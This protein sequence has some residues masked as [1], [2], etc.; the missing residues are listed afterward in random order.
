[1]PTRTTVRDIRAASSVIAMRTTMVATFVTSHA[2]R[3]DRDQCGRD[4]DPAVTAAIR[5]SVGADFVPHE[6]APVPLALLD[7]DCSN[8]GIPRAG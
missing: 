8:I 6:P 3:A 2:T 4:G 5:M 1:S 7:M